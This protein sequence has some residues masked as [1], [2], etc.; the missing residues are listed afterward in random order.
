MW[1]RGVV[2]VVLCLVGAVF[3]AQGS[4]ALH[5]S[6]MTGEGQWTV[7]GIILIVAG[8]ALIWWASRVRRSRLTPTP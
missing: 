3:T 6:S 1:W 5:G 8:L 4:G 2:G 7:I